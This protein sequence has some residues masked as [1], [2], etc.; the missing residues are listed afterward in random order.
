[1]TR[2][3]DR[4]RR[5]NLQRL[6]AE[7]GSAEALARRAETSSA[8]VSQI[9]SGTEY[10]K[11]KVRRVGDRLA[12]KLEKAMDK[13]VG[14]MD[15]PPPPDPHADIVPWHSGRDCPLIS[16]AEAGAW[17]DAPGFTQPEARLHCPIHCGPNTFALRIPGQSMEPRFQI[18]DYI[19]VDPDAVECNG[20]FVVVR[21]PNAGVATFR[22]LIQEDDRRYLKALNPE[23]PGR[24]V[25]A[26]DDAAVCGVV[27]FQ[28]STV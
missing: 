8:Y 7:A 6:I 25:Q 12:A 4:I 18:G 19:F 9:R 13:P 17:R 15:A 28:G 1:M 3:L 22:Q 5:R 10:A 20:G 11:G 27:V 2:Q 14:W 16:W 23:W 26:E 24:I 21:R